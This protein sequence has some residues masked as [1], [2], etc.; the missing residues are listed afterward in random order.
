M[1]KWGVRDWSDFRLTPTFGWWSQCS[2]F[3]M[4]CPP[5][6][7][8]QRGALFFVV[9]FSALVPYWQWLAPRQRDKGG[10]EAS[11]ARTIGWWNGINSPSFL[12]HA[13]LNWC[14][15]MEEEGVRAGTGAAERRGETL[16]ASDKLAVFVWPFKTIHLTA[17]TVTQSS[18]ERGW[19]EAAYWLSPLFRP[20]KQISHETWLD[21]ASDMN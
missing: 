11:A 9:C 6:S 5:V 17:T 12:I 20:G 16:S 18:H 4:K 1:L 19:W 7:A 10:W 2:L 13:H 21:T 3:L 15:A 14:C 8:A